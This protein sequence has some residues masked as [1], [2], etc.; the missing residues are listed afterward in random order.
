MNK[1]QIKPY[2]AFLFL[3][4]AYGT[5][6]A[7]VVI[8]RQKVHPM[9]LSSLRM[10]F[11][12]LFSIII[13]LYKVHKNDKYLSR[14]RQ[15]IKNGSTDFTKGILCGIFNYGFPYSLIA[16]SQRS[17]ATI[18][19]QISQPFVPI[20]SLIGG[21][22]LSIEKCSAQKFFYQFI[23]VVGTTI[24]SIPTFLHTE[25]NKSSC[26]TDYFLLLISTVSFGFGAV[27]LKY[28]QSK[29]DQTLLCVFQLL[30]AFLYSTFYGVFSLGLKQF[31]SNLRN[32]E[33]DSLFEIV[34]LGVFYTCLTSHCVVY[35]M[36]KLGLVAANYTNVGQI[37]I[38]IIIGVTFLGEWNEFSAFD[39]FLSIAG[40][41]VLFISIVFGMKN[42]TNKIDE[43]ENNILL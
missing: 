40:L 31:T 33:C 15:S 29:A 14:V 7:L 39:V 2:L 25:K 30:G 21:H 12:F 42:E 22:I 37:I 19:V 5:S 34:V 3:C 41:I 8:I 43:N 32:I 23:S 20:F 4:F 27:F 17:V 38:G 35:T 18:A 1:Y 24:S 26:I 9:I 11:G 13:F 6:S 16:I 36:K 10:F 28:F